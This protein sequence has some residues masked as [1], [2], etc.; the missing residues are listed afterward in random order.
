MHFVKLTSLVPGSEYEYRVK[1][2]GSEAVWS[3]QF[4]FRVPPAAGPTRIA[5]FGDV[6]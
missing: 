6:K 4:R 3:P 5:I 1:S 2:G